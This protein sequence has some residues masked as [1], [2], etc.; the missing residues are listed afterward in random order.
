MAEPVSRNVDA[1]TEVRR[2]ET[3]GEYQGWPAEDI[4]SIKAPTLIIIG[5][6]DI[7]R[8]EHALELFRLLGGG[9][10]GDIAGLPRPQLAVRPARLT[11][12]SCIVA[13][14]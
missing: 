3:A 10:A 4:Q 8:P 6:S 14:G 13:I 2:E 7:V 12:R 11:L 9:A 1:P 5:D